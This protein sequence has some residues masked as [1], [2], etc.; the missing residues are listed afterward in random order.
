[1]DKKTE[2]SKILS[3]LIRGTRYQPGDFNFSDKVN[4]SLII[5]SDALSHEDKTVV[6]INGSFE[7]IQ[8]SLNEF[9]TLVY[10]S[11]NLDEILSY[12]DEL[13][14]HL[15]KLIKSSSDSNEDHQ[16]LLFEDINKKY[17]AIRSFSDELDD[18][19]FMEFVEEFEESLGKFY[20]I[21]EVINGLE[22]VKVVQKEIREL[23]VKKDSAITS[24]TSKHE[25]TITDGINKLNIHRP[26][27]TK[28]ESKMVIRKGNNVY[29]WGCSTFP[30]CFSRRWFT[31][32]ESAM[33]G[34]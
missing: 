32:E 27:C 31:N 21:L 6:S 15:Q 33:V 10:T 1:M 22:I 9:K 4:L 14:P 3:K 2:I 7:E 19:E 18:I 26:T 34:Q 25:K 24:S 12:G 5:I 20:E 30:G 17:N 13:L 23:I 28:C 16:R 29:F 11:L 8:R